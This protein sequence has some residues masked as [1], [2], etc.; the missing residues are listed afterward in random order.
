MHS[1][2]GQ[3]Q[4]RVGGARRELCVAAGTDRGDAIAWEAQLDRRGVG[5]KVGDREQRIERARQHAAQLHLCACDRAHLVLLWIA[6]GNHVVH[7]RGDGQTGL[8]D[9]ARHRVERNRVQHQLRCDEPRSWC[10]VLA[11]G[12]RVQLGA[13]PARHRL[14]Q[15]L[16]S[17]AVS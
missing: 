5:G 12:R 14:G 10:R 13:T 9:D 1:D 16:A 3:L 17:A 6:L 7:H 4:P 11:N 15:A 8:G 2:V